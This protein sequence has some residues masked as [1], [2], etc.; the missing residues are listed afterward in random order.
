MD[1]II[2]LQDAHARAFQIIELATVHRLEK[3]PQCEKNN[4]DREGYQQIK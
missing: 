3:R 4:R 2:I 1:A